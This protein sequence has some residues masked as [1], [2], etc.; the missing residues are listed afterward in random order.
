MKRVRR[1]RRRRSLFSL[2]LVHQRSRQRSGG[3][4]PAK[5]LC[6]PIRGGR[7]AKREHTEIVTGEPAVSMP[8]PKMKTKGECRMADEFELDTVDGLR[9]ALQNSGV[10]MRSTAQ[11]P[12]NTNML[13]ADTIRAGG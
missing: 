11:G 6:G 4:P 12:G 13:V 1:P 10:L 2:C 3:R 9:G 8:D 5:I 7:S